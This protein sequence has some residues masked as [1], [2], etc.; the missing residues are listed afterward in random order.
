M[1]AVTRQG[2]DPGIDLAK[3]VA[4][5]AV[6]MIHSS[7]I[8]IAR[9]EIGSLSWLGVT[10]Y[11]TVSRW[12]VPLF[13]MCSGAI[14]NDPNRAVPLKKL[15]SK[16]LLRL[17]LSLVV[18]SSLYEGLSVFVLKDT[19]PLQQL[20]RESV[21]N[22]FYGNTHYHLYFFW[23]IFALYLALPL[24]RL[25]IRSAEEKVL[26]YILLLYITFG[27]IL[28]FLQYF[29][30]FS[31]MQA[32]LLYLIMA[33]TWFCPGLG[34]L[35]WYLRKHQVRHWLAPFLLFM[36]G[37]MVTML[38]TWIRSVRFG[39]W[40]GMYL[41]GFSPFVIAMAAGIFQLCQ[42]VGNRMRGS[43]GE[44]V[45]AVVQHFSMASFCIYLVHPALQEMIALNWFLTLPVSIAVP[46]QC[47]MLLILSL[48]IYDILRRI[49]I[50][51][52][53]LI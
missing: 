10:F 46:L 49:P 44:R 51:R 35:G 45:K 31:Q 7:A 4:I 32:S 27:C 1:N 8:H 38:G 37:F 15:F 34:L 25:V 40:E 47:S 21:K 50:V 42:Y 36:A 2:R 30:P 41:I 13:L 9:Y 22:V 11:G 24:T 33:P 20:L 14:M 6:V 43:L 5:G 23:P 12:A 26:R 16:Y 29:W 3:T 52:T 18:W 53:W 48:L 28:P 19:A 17:F 39:A